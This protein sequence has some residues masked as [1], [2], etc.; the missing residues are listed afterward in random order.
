MAPQVEQRTVPQQIEFFCPKCGKSC[1]TF[2]TTK[3]TVHAKPECRHWLKM[4]GN[5]PALA[6]FLIQAGVALQLG[7]KDA[8]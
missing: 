6:V 1:V 4:R 3:A 8:G 5:Q 7:T 2:P